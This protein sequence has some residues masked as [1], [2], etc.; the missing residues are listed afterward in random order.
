MRT[1]CA[2][3]LIAALAVVAGG[4]NKSSK[5]TAGG[6]GASPRAGNN[7]N[8]ENTFTLNPTSTVSVTQGEST[9][10][11]L[12]INRETNF[13]AE[14]TCRFDGLPAGVTVEPAEPVLDKG[15]TGVKV[16]VA[17]AA[18]AAT[19]DHQVTV[20]GKAASGGPAAQQ[21]FTITV[22]AGKNAAANNP[23]GENANPGNRTFVV[24]AKND[25]TVTQGQTAQYKVEINRVNG[26]DEPVTISFAGLPKNVTVKPAK[27]V[28][29][30]KT[31]NFTFNVTAG[32][33]ATPN[34]FTTPKVV[35]T[36]ETAEAIEKNFTLTVKQK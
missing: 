32:A 21:V 5:G 20:R 28:M 25:L 36:P 17:A 3:L 6:P 16:T 13:D 27:Q 30:T 24:G 14:V 8:K 35:A 31:A 9:Q 26:F 2:G 4:C 15:T 11:N 10:M 19:G 18:T 23:G 12:G 22:K 33:D 7:Q 34:K 1:W 29:D